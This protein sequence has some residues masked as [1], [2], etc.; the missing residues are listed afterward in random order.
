[1]VTVTSSLEEQACRLLEKFAEPDLSIAREIAA[2][3]SNLELTAHP[4]EDR[5]VV[6]NQYH[7]R[8]VP[9]HQ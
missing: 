3:I 2:A 9:S 1:M 5:V 8:D 7:Y 4:L 6:V